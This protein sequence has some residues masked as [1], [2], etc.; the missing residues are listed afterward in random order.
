[1]GSER[2][3]AAFPLPGLPGFTIASKSRSN[4]HYLA[5][6]AKNELPPFAK[7]LRYA[8]EGKGPI[9]DDLKK[10]LSRLSSPAEIQVFVSP[11]CTN[12][13]KVVETVTAFGA[14]N[15]D[16]SVIIID[17]QHFNEMAEGY[18]IKS[19]PGTVIDRELVLVGQVEPDRLVTLLEQRGTEDYDRELIRSLMDTG[20]ASMAAELICQGRGRTGIVA[21]FQEPEL[22]TRMGVLVVLEEA[23]EKDPESVREMVPSLIELLSHE[24]SRI[25]GDMADFLGSTGDT[26][27]IPHLE[28]LMSDPDPDVIEA[29][30]DAL[31]SLGD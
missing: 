13:P 16:L 12:C 18:G 22:S 29:A 24:D 8:S 6:P 27:V 25:R 10:T 17:V 4:I 1:L 9:S 21:L 23:L 11:F 7:A 14:V 15:P 3:D 5:V 31:E 28:N 26:R 19:V 30:S 2:T 20:R